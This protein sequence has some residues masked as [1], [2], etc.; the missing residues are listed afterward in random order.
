[1]L[2]SAGLPKNE[3]VQVSGA[4]PAAGAGLIVRGEPDVAAT[5][6]A[7]LSLAAV[8]AGVVTVAVSTV[9]PLET[10]TRTAKAFP[11]MA[12]GTPLTATPIPAASRVSTVP[13]TR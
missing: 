6:T 11:W 12:A 3:N 1:M 9:A 8:P 13:C 10:G 4:T 5:A 7:I 2:T